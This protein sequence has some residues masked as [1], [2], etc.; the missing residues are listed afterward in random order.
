MILSVKC[1]ICGRIVDARKETFWTK[2]EI[3][4]CEKCWKEQ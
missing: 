3:D 2:D 1:D 4:F